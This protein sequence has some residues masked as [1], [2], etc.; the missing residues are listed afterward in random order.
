MSRTR[1]L[2]VRQKLGTKW[3][4]GGYNVGT[5][6]DTKWAPSWAQNGYQVGKKWAQSWARSW[7]QS[8]HQVGRGDLTNGETIHWR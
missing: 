1:W 4:S 5:K 8:G 2:A 6:L 7:V 3:A